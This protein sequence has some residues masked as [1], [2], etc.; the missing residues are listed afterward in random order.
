MYLERTSGTCLEKVVGVDERDL[1]CPDGILGQPAIEGI[2]AQLHSWYSFG[3]MPSGVLFVQHIPIVSLIWPLRLA[4]LILK[5]SRKYLSG[6]VTGLE[7]NGINPTNPTGDSQWFYSREAAGMAVGSEA[8]A[9]EKNWVTV[10]KATQLISGRAG[11][12]LVPSI[13]ESSPTLYGHKPVSA[14]CT[15]GP[16]GICPLS[17]LRP[18]FFGRWVSFPFASYF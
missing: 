9:G 17:L 13:L 7:S 10:P 8:L 16:P 12:D 11:V 18:C 2:L 5:D 14:W 4:S 3:S 1:P 15:G 6:H